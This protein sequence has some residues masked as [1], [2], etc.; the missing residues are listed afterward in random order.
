MIHLVSK[1]RFASTI[2]FFISL[3]VW[4]R[5]MDGKLHLKQHFVDCHPNRP[6]IDA[7]LWSE[8]S[9]LVSRKKMKE[10]KVKWKNFCSSVLCKGRIMICLE[11]FSLHNSSEF[12]LSV[13]II[14][15]NFVRDI[16]KGLGKFLLKCWE[17]TKVEF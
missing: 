14:F 12:N 8:Q 17:T 2:S 4:G 5:E 15:R 7:E 1:I 6:S 9:S 10:R 16:L 11:V 3:R 13:F